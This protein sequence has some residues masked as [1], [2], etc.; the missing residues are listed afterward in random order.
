MES[1]AQ[2]SR[3][4]RFWLFLLLVTV[5]PLI[6]FRQA[7]DRPF[8][9]D[10]YMLFA[11]VSGVSYHAAPDRI[12]A[13]Q[14]FVPEVTREHPET[15]PWWGSPE[16]RLHFLRPLATLVLKLDYWIW[17]NNPTGFHLT[18]LLVHSLVCMILFLVGRRL[19]RDDTTA[20]L[21]VL[22]FT[23]SVRT[24]FVVSWVADR[25]VMLSLFWGLFGLYSHV[26]FRSN[27]RK[28]WALISWLCFI[29]AFLSKES[30]AIFV[31]AYFLFDVFIWRQNEPDAWPRLIRLG[32]RYIVFSIPLFL[33][34][35]Y[36]VLAG[37]GVAGPYSIVEG[38][39]T[40]VS[41]AGYVAK[42]LLLYGLGLL[43]HILPTQKVSLLL[44]H[45]TAYVVTLL[46]LI[47]LATLLFWPG[48]RRRTFLQG[49]YPFL[50][51]WL[52]LSLLPTLTFIPQ[53]RFL[54]TVS[55][56]FGLMMASYLLTMKRS[57]GFGRFTRSLFY[58][59][60]LHF[61]W[62]CP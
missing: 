12:S 16:I 35:A 53:D 30:G 31:A 42:N 27:G 10:D 36:F 13:Y 44:F 14:L 17:E 23:A 54:Y 45:Q 29:L 4:R 43:F 47:L 48:F 25:V 9:C 41:K 51:C 6:L 26:V 1:S 21:A 50:F 55:A 38:N 20:L 32:I 49:I 11:N 60:S 7:L 33:F 62:C 3:G 24:F 34:V 28:T 8:L 2:G 19:F 22:I 61:W 15:M 37:Y 5:L 46:I 56:P 39:G 18:N 52:L 58:S 57:A 59:A 40:L